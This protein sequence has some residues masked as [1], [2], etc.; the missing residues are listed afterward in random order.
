MITNFLLFNENVN[1]IQFLMAHIDI[2]YK[3]PLI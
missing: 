1:S 2:D 3:L